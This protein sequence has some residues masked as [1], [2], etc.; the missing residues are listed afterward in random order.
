[1]AALSAT[2]VERAGLI[3][4]IFILVYTG[5][6]WKERRSTWAIA[7]SLGIVLILYAG[8]ILTAVLDNSHYNGFL[9]TSPATLQS[10][11]EYPGF[12]DK[13]G[14]F[15]LMNVALLG[16]GLFRPKALLLALGVMLPN[17]LG[18]VGGAEKTG[19]SIHYHVLYLPFLVWAA[20]GGYARLIR[21]LQD[22]PLTVRRH[23]P[24]RLRRFD[25]RAASAV[26]SLVL[27]VG[28]CLLS[29]GLDP[30]APKLET[31]RLGRVNDLALISMLQRVPEYWPGVR[32]QNTLALYEQLQRAI[33]EGSV[34]TAPEPAIPALYRRRTVW[35]YPLGID[36][37]DY[38]IYAG[39][40][41]SYLSEFDERS[42]GECLL[43][44]MSAAGFDLE[45][46]LHVGYF[47]VYQRHDRGADPAP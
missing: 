32:R 6:Y 16:F 25:L 5:L 8:T 18:N 40:Q 42:I 29:V 45:H 30:Y 21:Y 14:V 35:M 22:P 26:C 7:V 46:P 28:L 39:G 43:N 3:L 1:L 2:I 38:V 27:V 17:M 23:L 15:L 44:Q 37:S 20:A 34:V 19:W 47:T 31:F 36:T 41:F 4:G 10:H 9:P 24:E 13:L 33:P 11:F 12:T